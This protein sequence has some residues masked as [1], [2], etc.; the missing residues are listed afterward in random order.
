[1]SK[2]LVA[3]ALLSLALSDVDASAGTPAHFWSQ[4]F[5]GTSADRGSAIA[6]DPAGFVVLTG[7]VQN[8]VNLGGTDLPPIGSTDIFVARYDAMGS[9]TWSKRFGGPSLDEGTA[10][11]VD[12]FGAVVVTGYFIGTVDFG[13]GMLTSAGNRDIFIVKFDA[14]GNH[15]WS[16]RFGDAGD[17]QGNSVAFDAAGNVFVT[18]KFFGTVNFGGGNLVANV[19]D[20]FIVKFDAAGTHQWSKRFGNADL[21]EGVGVATDALSNVIL[22]ISGVLAPYDFGGGPVGPG[23]ILVKYDGSGAHVWSKKLDL[24]GSTIAAAIATSISGDVVATGNFSSTIDF[25]GGSLVSAGLSD[26]FIVRFN[27]SGS[28]VWSRRAGGTGSDFGVDIA[29]DGEGSVTVTGNFQGTADFGGGNRTANGPTDFFIAKYNSSGAHEWSNGFGSVSGALALS[30]AVEMATKRP[31]VSA[32]YTDTI[33]I[34]G[35]NLVSAGSFDMV[36]A[37][38]SAVQREPYIGLILDIPNDQGGAVRAVFARSGFDYADQPLSAITNYGVWRRLDDL[39]AAPA[40]AI[41]GSISAAGP[42]VIVES[43]NP[44]TTGMPPG[45]WEWVAGIP[46]LQQDV[47]VAPVPTVEDSTVAG[48]NYTVLV[49]T[50]HTPAPAIW[51][52]SDP[53]SGYSI[54][55]LAPGVPTNLTY[56]AGVL[57]WNQSP[58]AD[59]DYFSVYGSN[60]ISFG[61]AT[62][63]DYTVAATL[64]VSSSAYSH[65]FVT[66]TDFAGNESLPAML[67]AP[68]DADG[69][70]TAFVLSVGNYPNPFNPGT[71]VK[72]TVPSRGEVTIAVYD[73]QGTRVAT[74]VNREVRAPGAYA[75]EWNGRADTGAAVSSGVYF[76]RIEHG[77]STRSKKMVMLK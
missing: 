12:G 43:T 23:G 8:T 24:G 49:V 44:I 45:I 36:V 72:Y 7:S 26:A 58:A 31:V 69:S 9:H 64:D 33:N 46:A 63:V 22:S 14:S 73:V 47:Y 3:T 56:V 5:G 30:V 74:L 42:G 62:L 57:S 77:G 50:A 28:H 4:R 16:K 18:G 37:K 20:G 55:N 52:V 34:G 40:A 32:R 35:G 19:V 66:A 59:F 53:D 21:E 48:V 1:M 27:S 51:Y 2:R 38:F 75:I 6:V 67:D 54:D 68:T 10:V 11:A 39:A 76:A 60:S 61:S 70:Q 65:Y 41:N 17:D 71:T 15:L 29:T 13:G 25:G